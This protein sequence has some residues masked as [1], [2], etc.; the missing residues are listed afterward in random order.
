MLIPF[1]IP[2]ARTIGLLVVLA[3]L[4]G[5]VSSAITPSFKRLS[6]PVYDLWQRS[7]AIEKAEGVTF[8]V[9]SQGS[10]EQQS[11]NGNNWPWPR[12]FYGALISVANRIGAKSVTLDMVFR[13]QSLHGMQ[14]DKAL[15]AAISASKIPIILAGEDGRNTPPPHSTIVE[16]I[17]GDHLRY[18]I[19]TVPPE[20]DGVLRRMPLQV[21][22]RPPVALTAA[23]IE[24]RHQTTEDGEPI[25]LRFY[26]RK[27]IPY[28]EVSDIF[29]MFR[30]FED[31]KSL[32][33]E[34]ETAKKILENTH[35]IVGSSAPGLLDLKPLPTEPYA[36]G[37]LIH[38]TALANI[39][40]GVSVRIASPLKTGLAGFIL[41]L[42]MGL[43]IFFC[44]T[45]IPAVVGSL[46]VSSFG[47]FGLSYL[48]W[49]MGWWINPLPLFLTSLIVAALALATRF[50]V[51]WRERERLARSIE[52]SMSAE[53]VDMIR[54]GDVK[55]TR[56]GEDRT[57]SIL[58]S[59]L[60]GFTTV[61]ER[62]NAGELVN[63]LNLYLDEVVELIFKHG[64]YVD[65]FIG[66]AVMALW[67]API[68][69][70]EGHAK[71]ALAC[72]LE[73]EAAVMRF[74]K[75]ARETFGLTED[76]FT[77]RVGVHTGPAI[78]GNVGSHSRYNYTAIGDS[79][80][81]ASRLEGIGKHYN[82]YLLVSEEALREAGRIED[83]EF[84]E[85]DVMAV[86]GRTKPTRIFTHVPGLSRQAKEAYD[87]GRKSYLKAQFQE[88]LKLFEA[89][90]A[91]ISCAK[92]MV[93]R[94]KR[95]IESGQLP[96]L[97]NGI[98][99]HDEK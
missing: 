84:V 32:S 16:G 28:V 46:S 30:F 97:R 48:A 81:L 55:L 53:M 41:F 10:L 37:A 8:V 86:K 45:P 33:L 43:A 40:Q 54:R 87:A 17:T 83:S 59:D 94:C 73:F 47:A 68:Q 39:L 42:F 49:G 96:S 14:D 70:P 95:G 50:Q 63:L 12:E 13:G 25:W 36:P 60:S 57:I 5:F 99:H 56:Y 85:V 22:G 92:T 26:K 1:K 77:A 91:E 71:N 58:F 88:A 66:D 31:G 38:A 23:A 27:G 69:D 80:N 52:N 67:G 2:P 78:V 19:V 24:G 6:W 9:I 3:M 61:S 15:N 65:K 76:L 34:L 4:V 11:E 29:E 18:G 51:E 72:S 20:R 79:V 7:T 21:N 44:V 89:A 74:N 64:G 35:W 93:E 62:L 98:W 82:T 75:K 90:A